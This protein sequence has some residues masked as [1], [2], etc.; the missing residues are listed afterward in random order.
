MGGGR[1]GAL[2]S[3]VISGGRP[4]GSRVSAAAW[5]SEACTE[6]GAAGPALKRQVPPAPT[7]AGWQAR[8]A[9]CRLTVAGPLRALVS[10]PEPAPPASLPPTCP[11]GARRGGPGGAGRC[12]PT[13]PQGDGAGP[14]SQYKP[15]RTRTAP[16]LSVT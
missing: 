10:G 3:V 8:D 12:P 7:G 5:T 2:Q 14:G 13:P 1:K 11:I 6:G 4:G 15:P 9:L 16:A